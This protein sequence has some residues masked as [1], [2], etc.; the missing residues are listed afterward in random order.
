M[1]TFF[2]RI[3]S[4]FSKVWGRL[5]LPWRFAI[6]SVILARLFYTLWSFA[7]LSLFPVAIQNIDLSGKPVLTVFDLR[8]SQRSIYART[9][10]EDVLVFRPGNGNFVRDTHTDSTWEL[11]SGKAV[12]GPLVGSRLQIST[13]PVESIFPY[14]GVEANPT[15]LLAVWQHFD[16]NWYLS[17]AQNGYGRFPDD[18]HFAPLY[19]LLIRLLYPFL[20]NW[21]VA[22]LIISQLSVFWLIKELYEV[23]NNLGG[24]AIA[25]K[26]VFYMLV[27]PSAF[28]LFSAYAEPL[29][30]L[31]SVL[32]LE[33]I[34]SK[35]W[36]LA[37]FWIA[38]AILSRVQGVAL[39]LPLA[40]ALWKV[41]RLNIS[42]D[43]FKAFIFPG[44]ATVAYIALRIVA[45]A[46]FA[47]P[48]SEPSVA[49][50][51]VWPWNNFMAA[52]R[53]FWDGSFTYIN[54]VNF[55]L[56]LLIVVLLIC[57]WKKIPIEYSLYSIACIL[58]LVVR[59]VETQPLNPMIRYALTIPPVFFMLA[60]LSQNPWINRLIL[61]ISL[62]LGL[63][64]SAQFFMWGF[65]A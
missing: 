43:H 8:T 54:V 9:V 16:A 55:V 53:L 33:R 64:L 39:V 57:G 60:R 50:R 12:D 24:R 5:S 21:L 7:V 10:G 47:I 27:F 1:K 31:T 37:G 40:Y 61:V 49:A 19:P 22:G 17:I 59:E 52:F 13:I 23:Y 51:L 14:K 62:S 46:P 63:Y 38:C 6:T 26:S 36:M 18:T 56:T 30:I 65:V 11:A 44:L 15:P 2:R 32:A 34:R 41:Y 20:R 4:G 3:Y 29:F 35:R 48:V 28:F 42:V 25:Q 58:V 45:G